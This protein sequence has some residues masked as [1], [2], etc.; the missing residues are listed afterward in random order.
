VS[1]PPT[2]PPPP[3]PGE[4]AL[5]LEEGLTAFAARE[6]EVAHRAFERAHRRDSRD[7]RAMSW[8]GVTLVLVERNIA[9]GMSLCDQA[10][11]AALDPE[12]LLNQARVH[13]AL[14][15]RERAVKSVERGL[16]LW[17]EHV[18]LLAARQAMGTRRPPVLPFL[19]RANPLNR[20]LGR[21][22]HRWQRRHGPPAE[23]SPLAL[24]TTAGWPNPPGS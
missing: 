8:Y 19:A 3:A 22:R 4:A 23:L 15:Q 21:L 10:V 12:L 24:G 13:L 6:L 14:R 18:A 1:A 16:D 20:M 2:R 5:A 9:L 7:L 11:R 17:P